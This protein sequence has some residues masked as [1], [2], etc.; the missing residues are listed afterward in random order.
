M[1]D[2]LDPYLYPGTDV[3]RNLRGFRHQEQL[4]AF[5]TLNSAARAYELLVKPVDG[6]FDTAHLKAI[7][8]YLFQDV[9]GWAGGFRSTVLG[10]S[11]YIGAPAIWFTQP[12]LLEH[13]AARIFSNLHR[14]KLLRDLPRVEFAHRA[15]KL[16]ADINALHP[17]REGNGR[18]QRIFVAE[19][20]RRVGHTIHFDVVS[21][22][23][24]L[25]ASI[26]AHS[27]RPGMMSRL[28]EEITDAERIEPLRRAI[29]FLS[30]EKFKWNDTYIAT[31]TA[32]RHYTGKLVGRAG[33]DFMMRTDDD[34]II[35]G[36]SLD[37]K[38]EARNG[39][40]IALHASTPRR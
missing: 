19:V 3:L 34:R 28:F 4:D 25:N 10:K 38:P 39:D 32:G 16:L 9:F 18:T 31:A 40:R 5:E 30:R 29:A 17:F 20:G 27:G 13:E 11:A 21:R 26:E 24:M 6:N 37:L 12:H 8:R 7:H 2:A 23:R 14:S 33:M 35:I 15:A 1:S 36:Q 22:E